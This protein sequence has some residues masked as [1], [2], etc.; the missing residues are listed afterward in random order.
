[1]FRDSYGTLVTTVPGWPEGGERAYHRETCLQDNKNGAEV[2]AMP[3]YE[4]KTDARSE[5]VEHTPLHHTIPYHILPYHT[6]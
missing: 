2:R 6:T 3:P 5:A 1:M 4:M